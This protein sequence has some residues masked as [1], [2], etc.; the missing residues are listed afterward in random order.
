[1]NEIDRYLRV[2]TDGD[3]SVFM[4]KV[5]VGQGLKVA[6][7]QIAAEEL[8]LS[9]AR[10]HIVR[11]D[12][13]VSANASYTA[14]S[15]SIQMVGQEVRRA[16]ASARQIMVG[17]AAERWGVE[18]E[19]LA[20][21]DGLVKE[22]GG[23]RTIGY[24]E[25]MG[26]RHFERPSIEGVRCKAPEEYAV[27]GRAVPRD[28]MVA[29][30]TGGGGFIHD[31]ELPNM[32]HGRVVRP[33]GPQAYLLALDEEQ[34]LVLPGVVA[35][36][37]D[38]SFVGVVAEREEQAA[39]A[40]EILR[41]IATWEEGE[42]LPP[43][44][45]L[46]ARLK[47]GSGKSLLVVD[48]VPVEG[49]VPPIGASVAGAVQTL[50]ACYTKP[51]HLHASL[52]PSA[53]LAQWDDG[54]LQV[55]SHTQGVFPLRGALAQV[56]AIEEE[57]VRVQHVEGAGCYGHNG[58]D[59]VALDAA[60][61]ARA[62][63]GRPVR[64]QWMRADEHAWEASG[65]AMVLEMQGS[66]D[67]EGRVVDWNHDVWSYTHSG[68][69][70]AL[71]GCSNLLAAWHLEKALPRPTPRAG[72]GSHGG[73][74][75]NADPLYSFKKRRVVKHFV[76][77]SPL[78]VSA[79]RGLGAYGNVFAI[80]SFMDELALAAKVDPLE[81]R[82]RHL[83]DERARAVL[84]RAAE[85]AGWEWGIKEGGCGAGRGLGISFAQ[86]KN[87]KCYAAVVAQVCVEGDQIQ[88]ERMVIAADAGLI[89]NP[90]GMA[91]QLEGGVLQ[92]ASWTLKE[93]LRYGAGGV[94]CCD[95]D[96]Y[97][98]LRFGETPEIEVILIDRP[99]EPSKGCGEATQGPTPAAIANAVFVACGVRLRQVPFT[100]ECLRA[101]SIKA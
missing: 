66:L 35:V 3:I 26:G 47:T 58:A 100:P 27:V 86:Y 32:A 46:Y 24:G 82:L 76:E 31:L 11:A 5:E 49:A 39:A 44:E 18:V 13:A 74:H 68:R 93:E 1:M 57:N 62:T 55:W 9:F 10:V 95:W 59:D 19:E 41:T 90:D 63:P 43:Q 92:A 83:E 61:L 81:F 88:L 54:F 25:L 34:V 73:I 42:V 98:I 69:P 12:T 96:S 97:P 21:E 7:A 40:A 4:S 29:K 23:Q 6:I 87:E 67:A 94:E 50:R 78:R 75:R 30:V 16:A 52:G 48:G 77:D 101:A 60:L 8:D 14:G 56:L 17:M 33:P 45:E 99:G 65:S 20:V 51:F 28:D 85:K 89:V 80:E 22:R 15:N 36:V 91:N 72:G 38:G 79:L 64:V 53:A 84:E 70:R 37:R 71:E 2:E